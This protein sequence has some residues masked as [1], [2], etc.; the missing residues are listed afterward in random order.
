MIVG[1]GIWFLTMRSLTTTIVTED[2]VTFAELAGV[3]AAIVGGYVIKNALVPQLT[4][5]AM[6]LDAIFSGTIIAEQGVLVSR[7]GS[8][9]SRQ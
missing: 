3:P 4:G 6:A 1:L 2:Y 5:L 8:C 7:L 9:W